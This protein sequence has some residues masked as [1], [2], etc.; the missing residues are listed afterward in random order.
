MNNYILSAERISKK[1][2]GTTV[3]RDVSMNI[4]RGEIY[5]LIGQN[6]SG[7][8]TLLRILTDFFICWVCGIAVCVAALC[9]GNPLQL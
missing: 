1:Y 2:G 7:K 6:G 9:A 5:G 3:L 8:T 4:K